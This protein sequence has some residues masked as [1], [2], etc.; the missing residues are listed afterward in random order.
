MSWQTLSED[1]EQ[2]NAIHGFGD[3]TEVTEEVQKAVLTSL[4]SWHGLWVLAS[5]TSGIQ[6]GL[7]YIHVHSR[8]WTQL[9]GTIKYCSF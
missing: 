1:S 3:D 9:H 2:C 7:G 5:T 6:T 8:V 4:G